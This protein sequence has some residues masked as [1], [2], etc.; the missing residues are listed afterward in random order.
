LKD[1]DVLVIPS[2]TEISPNVAL[3]ARRIG[4]PVLLTEENGL[5]DDLRLGMVIAPLKTSAEIADALLS[6]MKNYPA[7]AQGAA[8][9]LR[10]RTWRT[11][12]LEH[13]DLFQSLL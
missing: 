1:H 7:I 9:P 8:A 3:E 5:S 10:E 6:L 13:L 2:M 4:L 12:A 11:V